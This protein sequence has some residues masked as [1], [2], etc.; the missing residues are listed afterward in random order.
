MNHVNNVVYLQW[1]QDVAEAH[2]T[3]KT[4]INIRK[5]YAWVVVNH[6]I[7]YKKS[8]FENEEITLETWVDNYS[9][10]TCER[11]TNIIRKTDNTLLATAKTLWCL[12]DKTTGK[13]DRITN[14]LKELF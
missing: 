7:E 3:A 4:T 13:P 12:L 1:V 8:A 5:R 2:W 9:T 6:F 10:V 14:E 11:H